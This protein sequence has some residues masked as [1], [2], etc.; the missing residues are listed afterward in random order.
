MFSHT[1]THTHTYTHTQGDSQQQQQQQQQFLSQSLR[2]KLKW[3]DEDGGELNNVQYFDKG[4]EP[5]Q[6]RGTMCG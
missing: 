4:A 2:K 5:S 6:V 3:A 1:H